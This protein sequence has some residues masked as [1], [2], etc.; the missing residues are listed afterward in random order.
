[1]GTNKSSFLWEL[2]KFYLY[3]IHT[4]KSIKQFRKPSLIWDSII[5]FPVWFKFYKQNYNPLDSD[6]PWIVFKAKQFLDSIINKNMTV[7][8]YGS[9]GSTLYFSKRVSKVYSIE[10][11]EGWYNFL[12]KRIHNTKIN[13]IDD[14][15]IKGIEV[16]KNANP[17]YTS[18][19]N[20]FYYEDYVKIIDSFP[21]NSFD[22][23]V[24]DGRA[25]TA[26]VQHAV[27]KIKKGGYLLL[28]NSERERY[29][30]GNDFLFDK[31]KWR[32]FSFI[33]PIT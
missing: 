30:E 24:V 1:M 17:L 16:P 15:L 10:N 7:F 12:N 2:K 13:N 27:S 18:D 19:A 6:R 23:V 29:L 20:G 32:E 33:G 25:R 9:G 3:P 31:N 4:L 11:D 21:D 26:C 14:T 8:E 5:Y 28:D 22:I